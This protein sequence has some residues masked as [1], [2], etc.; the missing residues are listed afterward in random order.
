MYAL[1][2]DTDTGR[3]LSAT[4]AKYAAPSSP[5]VGVLPDGNICDYLY[6]DGS[7]VFDPLPEPQMPQPE[8]TT[9]E[10]IADLEE[11]IALLLSGVTE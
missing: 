2:I 5:I 6:V 3:I 10:R 4:F 7:Y 9:E 8:P 11:A 1:N